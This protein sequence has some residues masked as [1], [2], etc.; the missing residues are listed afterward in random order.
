MNVITAPLLAQT[1][2][3]V[4]RIIRWQQ[5]ADALLSAHFRQHRLGPRERAFVAETAYALLR[6]WRSLS[7]WLGAH[8]SP[9]ELVLAT[10]IQ[11]RG[12]SLRMLEGALGKI[13]AQWLRELKARPQAAPTL[14][15]R[16]ELPDWLL[17]RLLPVWGEAGL[18]E[19]ADGLNTPAPLDLR[20]NPLK[21]ERP[22]ALARLHADGFKAVP[23]TLSPLAIR[24]TGRPAL[25]RHPLFLDGSLEVQ[26]EGSQLLA[27]LLAPRRGERVADFCAGTGGKTLA[28]GAL[29]RSTGRLYAFDVSAARLQRLKPR[30]ARSGL[31]NVHPVAIADENDARIKRLAGKLDRVLVDAPCS[32]LG[33]LR[34]NP[35]LKWRQSAQAVSE[36]AAKQA[37][38]LA[39]AS[40]LVKPGGRLVYATCSILAEENEEVVAAFLAA[41]PAF[42]R[43]DA[44]EELQRHGVCLPAENAGDGPRDLHLWPQRHGC[45]GFYAALLERQA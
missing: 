44:P 3:V 22:A 39:A 13:E 28:L 33:T 15:E 17:E 45:D 29:M 24:V 1:V 18:I 27:F 12:Y 37:R 23:G 31:S 8:A 32:G 19:L 16:C 6:H 10:L 20:V 11:R 9:R 36:L 7:S 38:I 14:A 2:D 30:L 26:D 21:I 5:P 40:R 35:D 34:R 25:N 41:Q 43:C 42:R 4:E